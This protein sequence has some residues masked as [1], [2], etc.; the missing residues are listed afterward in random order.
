MMFYRGFWIVADRGGDGF[1]I[2]SPDGD[3]LDEG[4]AS[5]EDACHYIDDIHRS[6]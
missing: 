2:L 6:V 3:I 4:F 5:A 1:N